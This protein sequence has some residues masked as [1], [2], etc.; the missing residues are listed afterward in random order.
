MES[1]HSV[2]GCFALNTTSVFKPHYTILLTCLLNLL[3]VTSVAANPLSE[4][5]LS[6]I[7]TLSDGFSDHVAEQMNTRIESKQVEFNGQRVTYEYQ[8]WRLR[9]NSVCAHL[10]Q[11]LL[12]FS[13][14]GQTAQQFFQQTCR[15]LNQNPSSHWAHTRQTQLYCNAASQY[16]PTIAEVRR[17]K[18]NSTSDASQAQRQQCSILRME[19][20]RNKDPYVIQQR[21]Q[22][23]NAIE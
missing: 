15:Y 2:R 22:V 18:P 8:L 14:C 9:P 20:L 4:A 6:F 3:T 11:D 17:S 16:K 7:R 23:C 21:D 12:A 1:T 13:K 5:Y 19:A 10:K